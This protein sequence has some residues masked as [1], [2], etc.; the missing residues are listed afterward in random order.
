M[1]ERFS[2]TGPLGV[3]WA[4]T[5]SAG[6]GSTAESDYACIKSVKPSSVAAGRPALQPGL[7][8]GYVNGEYVKGQD[9]CERN[10]CVRSA[11][12][13][14]APADWRKPASLLGALLRSFFADAPADKATRGRRGSIYLSKT[15]S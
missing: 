2:E 7:I 3:V 6:K 1:S 8:L 9:Y 11:C 15:I 5:R 13:L 10:R 4:H 14:A 12:A